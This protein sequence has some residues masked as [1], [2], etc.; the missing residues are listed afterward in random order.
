MP[1]ER[2]MGATLLEAGVVP[3]AP[4]RFF[5]ASILRSKD[6]GIDQAAHEMDI[7]S[8]EL[9]GFIHGDRPVDAPFARRLSAFTGM[10]PQF[11]LNMQA[12]FELG[13]SSRDFRPESK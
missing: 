2:I 12:A 13:A 9:W 11:W 10:S 6:Y 1:G 7:P 4:G 8:V 5:V 3:T